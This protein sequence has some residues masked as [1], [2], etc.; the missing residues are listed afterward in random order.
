M[1]FFSSLHRKTL[2]NYLFTHHTDNLV[3][4]SHT[5]RTWDRILAISVLDIWKDL[6]LFVKAANRSKQMFHVEIPEP[7]TTNTEKESKRHFI[8]K[9]R[10][11]FS[12]ALETETRPFTL[13]SILWFLV[14]SLFLTK[15]SLNSAENIPCWSCQFGGRTHMCFRFRYASIFL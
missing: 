1:F 9:W 2:I 6:W 14:E 3:F 13:H 15:S 5:W 12:S 4:N 8:M 11:R 7:L 10:W